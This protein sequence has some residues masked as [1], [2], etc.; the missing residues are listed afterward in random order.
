MNDHI[1]S[2]LH[3]KSYNILLILTDGAI[4]DMDLT[5]ELIVEGSSLPFSIIIVGVGDG[6]FGMMTDLDADDVI[7][8]TKGGK[9]AKRDIVQFVEHNEF[10]NGD[11]GLLAEEVLREVP[12]QIVGYM[13]MNNIY[14]S[15]FEKKGGNAVL[16]T[17]TA[18]VTDDPSKI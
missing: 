18:L 7:L 11:P 3:E 17:D 1:K 5:K 15:S 8:R 16:K 13:L 9:V 4:H 10:K 2:K 12:D 14:P 6:N